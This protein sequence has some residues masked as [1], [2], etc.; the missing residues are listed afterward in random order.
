MIESQLFTLV[1]IPLL[2]FF[3]RIIDVSIGTIRV[4][5]VSKGFKY[6]APILGFFEVI[7][8]LV[9]IRQIMD[10]LTNVWCF[11]AYG[12][13]F[14][15]GTYFGIVLEEK[16]SIGKVI[17]RI[18]T[19]INPKNI[20][21][22]IDGE[23][24]GITRIKGENSK[25]KVNVIFSVIEKKNLEKVLK[26]IQEEAPKSFYSVEEV[27]YSGSEIKLSQKH[28]FGYFRKGK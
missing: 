20:I 24:L 25:G 13:G 18:I 21:E 2:I 11:I 6:L 1:G 16:I 9:A 23:H 26:I 8:W 10:N 4:I 14:A 3:A 15:A 7:V 19:K 12:A 28:R 5:F 22:R 27:K 17:V